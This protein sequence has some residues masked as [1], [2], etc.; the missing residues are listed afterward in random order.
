VADLVGGRV[1]IMFDAAPSLIQHVRSGKLRVLA[2][3]SPQR[4]RLLPEV[5][6]FAELGYP[7]VAVSLWYGLLVPAGTPR[8]AIDR[9]NR[10]TTKVLEQNEVR[11]KLLAQG[12][13][14]MP[15]APEAFAS[16]MRDEMAKWAPVVKQAGVKLD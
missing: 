6:T 16:F 15:G 12:A 8:P 11:E 9:L 5:P 1:Q 4:N 2:A 7:Q 3:A 10:E 14:P 13:E